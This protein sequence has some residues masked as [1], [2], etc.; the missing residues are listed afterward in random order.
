[1]G[2][3]TTIRWT[4]VVALAALPLLSGMVLAEAQKPAAV[5]AEDAFLDILP[6]IEVPE[7]VQPIPGAVNEEFRNC[8]ASWPPEYEASQKGSEARAFRDIYGLV[9]VRNVILTQD[10]SCVG[11]VATWGPVEAVATKLKE[12]NHVA[13][14][15]AN[16]TE[17]IHEESESL[18]PVTEVMCAGKF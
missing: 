5:A 14:L 16:H 3:M 9:K 1:M 18:F 12:L 8:R 15:R 7:D 10:C 6:K 4:A 11:K 17:A 13:E 2:H